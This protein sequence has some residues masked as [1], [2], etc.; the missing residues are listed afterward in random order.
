M[1]RTILYLSFTQYPKFPHFNPLPSTVRILVI[2]HH[3][4]HRS[5]R[6][7]HCNAINCHDHLNFLLNVTFDKPISLVLASVKRT[8]CTSSNWL[9]AH[10]FSSEYL[11]AACA[12]SAQ[13][14]NSSPVKLTIPANNKQRTLRQINSDHNDCNL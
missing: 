9:S 10:L 8:G 1:K 4:T 14:V 13:H 11:S 6:T 12:D 3:S 5:F 2:Y 7:I